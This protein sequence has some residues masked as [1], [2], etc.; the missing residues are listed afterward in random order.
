MEADEDPLESVDPV[1]LG[2]AVPVYPP[3][4]FPPHGQE[5]PRTVDLGIRLRDL[6]YTRE[7]MVGTARSVLASSVSR[8]SGAP[9][10]YLRNYRVIELLVDTWPI[11]ALID[12]A[13]EAWTRGPDG[14]ALAILERA[15]EVAASV[16]GWPTSLDRRWPMPD[17]ATILDLAGPGP[18]VVIGRGGQDG[19]P[20]VAVTL[21]ARL[22][23]IEPLALAPAADVHGDEL[24]ARRGELVELLAR[25]EAAAVRFT[26]PPPDD[27]ESR[28]ALEDIRKLAVAQAAFDRYGQAGLS[29][30]TAPSRLDD[31]LTDAPPGKVGEEVVRCC[32][33]LVLPTLQDGEM[34]AMGTLAWDAGYRPVQ[35]SPGI[36]ALLS[37]LEQPMRV[38]DLARKIQVGE[39]ELR[40]VLKELAE[41]GAITTP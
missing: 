4:P 35:V 37:I 13:R 10:L 11:G 22:G 14:R 18:H 39:D 6:L 21:G 31:V 28:S 24:V 8:M 25:G 30:M 20:A 27:P 26:C 17:E 38:E 41:V 15:A 40:P 9:Q 5:R 16:L 1:E 12:G 34:R 36:A 2:R 29:V 7:F 3:G 32:S 23:P 33:I 19:A